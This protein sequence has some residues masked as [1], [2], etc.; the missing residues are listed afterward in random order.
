MMY[1][2]AKL[3][4]LLHI[5][6]SWQ[7]GFMRIIQDQ[8]LVGVTGVIL[9]ENREVLLFRHTYRNH[10]WS[11]P[12]G[13]VKSKEHPKEGLEREIEEET[14]LVV[15]VD[16]RYKI[17]TDRDSARLDIVYIGSWIGGT[18]RPS[19]EVSEARFFSFDSLPEIQKS[20]LILIEKIL[21]LR[22]DRLG[23]ETSETEGPP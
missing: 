5:P 7:L 16:T 9:N 3:W 23:T 21:S 2:L 20:Q 17:R 19:T 22:K 1:L 18:F 15:S 12:G 11:L 10:A 13:Y 8:F 6:T 14:G 4:K